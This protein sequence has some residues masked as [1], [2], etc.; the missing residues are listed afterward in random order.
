MISH[1]QYVLIHI[2]LWLDLPHPVKTKCV[3]FWDCAKYIIIYFFKIT[4]W[5]KET[6]SSRIINKKETL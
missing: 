5:R 4:L 3:H 2:L 1:M 6:Y